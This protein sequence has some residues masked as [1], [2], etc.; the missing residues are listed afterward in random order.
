MGRDKAFLELGGLPLIA[1]AIHKLTPLCDSY[2]ICGNNPQLAAWGRLIPDA[3]AGAGPL[4]GLVSAITDTAA[5]EGTIF[6][7]VV[8]V[9]LPLLPTEVM[10]RLAM[11]AIKSGKWATLIE[12]DGHIQ[13]LCAIYRGEMAVP[14]R[15]L[16]E[17]GERKV[18]PAVDK[19]CPGA[20]MECVSL[21]ELFGVGEDWGEGLP[22]GSGNWFL[23]VNTPAD[24]E[25][26]EKLLP[27]QQM[28]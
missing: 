7:I 22:D 8:P 1:H 5:A 9:D 16:L 19:V 15:Q 2:A 27:S 20:L 6:A 28:P 14:L 21:A 17:S 25:Q 3:V 11:R 13:P 18:L 23:N 4:A 24:W 10:A 12:A 26:A